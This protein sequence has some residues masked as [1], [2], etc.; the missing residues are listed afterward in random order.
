MSDKDNQDVNLSNN[1]EDG[2]VSQDGSSTDTSVD[3]S[4]GDNDN[5]GGVDNSNND[6]IDAI[7]DIDE[8]R[9]KFK[10]K[11]TSNK[12]LYARLQDAKGLKLDKITGKWVPKT[13]QK[14]VVKNK[15]SNNEDNLSTDDAYTL[16][17]A[18]VPKEDVSIVKE[19]AKLNNKTIEEALS[20]SLIIGM[21]AERKEERTTANATSTS[22]VRRSNTKPNQSELLRTANEKGELPEDDQAMGDLV[23][24]RLAQKTK[25]N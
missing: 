24:A 11:D 2:T 5:N 16:I 15:S 17:Q 8:L 22:G 6:D 13:T 21:L 20:A 7:T 14:V 4:V 3:D 12:K 18:N 1:A 9:E 19:Y 23:E 25:K 10:I